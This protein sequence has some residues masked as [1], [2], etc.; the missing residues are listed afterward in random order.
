MIKKSSK[1]INMNQFHL[2]TKDPGPAVHAQSRD[3]RYFDRRSKS[4]E[5]NREIFP[6][7]FLIIR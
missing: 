5:H 3:F 2:H 4:F 7:P 1:Y 6:L